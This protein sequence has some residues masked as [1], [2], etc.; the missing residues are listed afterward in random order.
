M[1]L[2]YLAPTY[3]YVQSATYVNYKHSCII[4]VLLKI[5]INLGNLKSSDCTLSTEFPS[6]NKDVV[7]CLTVSVDALLYHNVESTIKIYNT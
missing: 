6:K 1:L 7:R 4:E 3:V 5:C 2:V